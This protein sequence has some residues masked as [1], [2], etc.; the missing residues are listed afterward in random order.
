MTRAIVLA[1]VAVASVGCANTYTAIRKV[2]D[3]TYILTRT[4]QGFGKTYGTVYL[5]KPIGQS[6]DLHCVVLDEP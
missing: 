5:C 2:D 6:A 4:K 1:L 3:N